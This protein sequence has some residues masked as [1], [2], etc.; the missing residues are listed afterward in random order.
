MP[1]TA[2]ALPAPIP[3]ARDAVGWPGMPNG[4]E[5]PCMEAELTGVTT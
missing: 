5:S 1:S 3:P 4:P 2:R